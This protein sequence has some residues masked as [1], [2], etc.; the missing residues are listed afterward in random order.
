MNSFLLLCDVFSFVFWKKLKSTKRHFEINWPLGMKIK[1]FVC[2][3]GQIISNDFFL[4]KDSPKKRNKTGRILVKTN[5]FVRFLGESSAWLFLFEINWPL[6]NY[7]KIFL[8]RRYNFSSQT[9]F[10]ETLES[11]DVSVFVSSL[12]SPLSKSYSA[13]SNSWSQ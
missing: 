9:L 11:V 10:Y 12:Q 6:C 7:L 1:S 5:A 3:K 2:P 8:K 4:A 13:L